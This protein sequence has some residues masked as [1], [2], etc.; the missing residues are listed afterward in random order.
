MAN[1]RTVVTP[2]SATAP[3]P[4]PPRV[5]L[6]PEPDRI[7]RD[8]SGAIVE[9]ERGR[10]PA[11]VLEADPHAAVAV[12][13]TETF[14]SMD[15]LGLEYERR[16]AALHDEVRA[17][18]QEAQ[19]EGAAR[20]APVARARTERVNT[21]R[22]T[23]DG[24]LS[25]LK[26]DEERELARVR[27]ETMGRFSRLRQE[28]E[29]AYNTERDAAYGDEKRVVTDAEGKLEAA[30]RVVASGANEK[31]TQLDIWL[32]KHMDKLRAAEKA[33]KVEAASDAG[34]ATPAP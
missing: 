8:A 12:E 20:V 17:T 26:R 31:K 14:A 34:A 18:A 1:K 11:I 16:L 32:R 9:F 2:E 22:K 4:E 19:T 25:Q 7:V 27:K 24:V 3:T 30:L 10:M 6:A 28:A 15:D 33:K 13:A 23:Y 21:A 5:L 29:A